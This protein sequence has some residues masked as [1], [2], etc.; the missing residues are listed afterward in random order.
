MQKLFEYDVYIN[1]WRVLVQSHDIRNGAIRSRHIAENA[2]DG[3]KIDNMAVEGR[4]IVDFAI[5]NEK[6][7]DDAVSSEKI[8]NGAIEGRH[9]QNDAVTAEKIAPGTLDGKAIVLNTNFVSIDIEDNGDIVVYLGEGGSVQD[10][11]I[12]EETGD[13]NFLIEG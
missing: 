6:M 9:I 11:Y 10:V 1:D 4:H 2:I 13:V 3:S 8:E 5:T 12:D 7:A